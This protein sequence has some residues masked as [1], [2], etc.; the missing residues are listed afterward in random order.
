MEATLFESLS[1]V[2]IAEAKTKY[3][4]VPTII[5]MLTDLEAKRKNSQAKAIEALAN[6][7][8]DEQAK[9]AFGDK[10]LE[11]VKLPA[12][13]AGIVNVY[14]AYGEVEE[15]DLSKTEEVEIIKDGK[16]VKESR[17]PKVKVM[18]WIIE[19]NKGFAVDKT[20]GSTTTVSKRA[21]TVLKRNALDTTKIDTIGTF[22]T[23]KAAADFLKLDVGV[24]SA[25]LILAKN[26]Y[27]LEPYG[28]NTFTA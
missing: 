7:A 27:I 13:P 12:P 10:L 2:Q 20:S 18:K 23:G 17:H 14:M 6:Q 1:D 22:R 11:L 15:E 26:G 5:Q 8:K 16:P 3:K 21:I 25:N 24:S 4:N 9:K 28:G 19:T